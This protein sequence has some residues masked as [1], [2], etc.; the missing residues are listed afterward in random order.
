[1][2]TLFDSAPGFD[3]PLAVLKHCHDRI[4]KQLATMEKL[5]S[6]LND[7][8]ID[9]DAQHAAKAVL[10]YFRK[11]APQHHDDEEIDLL[12]E[13]AATAVGDDATLLN[14]L[15]AQILQ[16]HG[17]MGQQWKVLET[18]LQEIEDGEGADLSASDV[19]E[20]TALYEEHMR[21][22][23]TQ[24]APMAARLFNE[25]Q[26]KKLGAAMQARRGITA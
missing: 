25:E 26:M 14:A 22:E 15:T 11:A 5:V 1:M 6:H 4:R 19:E 17:Q 23:E 12:P 9:E 3:Q 24:I 13:L 10:R 21:I 8:G 16:Q 7:L 18:Q 2:N 20:F